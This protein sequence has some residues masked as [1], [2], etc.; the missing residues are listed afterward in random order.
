MVDRINWADYVFRD[1]IL[2]ITYVGTVPHDVVIDMVAEIVAD[3][4]FRPGM[5]TLVDNRRS[6]TYLEIS[7]IEAVRDL[8]SKAHAGATGIRRSAIISDDPMIE[9]I[10]RLGQ[11]IFDREAA[12]L[13]VAFRHFPVNAMREAEAW[14]KG[15]GE[16]ERVSA[17]NLHGV[18]PSLESAC[19]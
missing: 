5:P 3:S 2:R 12:S 11:T 10:V 19:N 14:L 6:T 17:A 4:S 13:R 9:N 18:L 1:G 8:M 16:D 7:R 15:G